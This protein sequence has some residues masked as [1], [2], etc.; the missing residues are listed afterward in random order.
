[1]WFD[2]VSVSWALIGSGVAEVGVA[3]GPT[4]SRA[5]L[6]W[7]AAFFSAISRVAGLLDFAGAIQQQV[8][9]HQ[10]VLSVTLDGKLLS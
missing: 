8:V 4:G 2:D 3:A 7:S 6:Q 5:V 1:M 9:D 10:E